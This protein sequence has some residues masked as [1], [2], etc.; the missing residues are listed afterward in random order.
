MQVLFPDQADTRGVGPISFVISPG[1]RAVGWEKDPPDLMQQLSR[2]G[3]ACRNL[4][5]NV[6]SLDGALT[7]RVDAARRARVARAAL[8]LL[9]RGKGLSAKAFAL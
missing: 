3:A 4:A 7:T 6:P 5:I 2:G 9:C 1:R 8:S